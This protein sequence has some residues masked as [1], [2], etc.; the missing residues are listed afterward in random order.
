MARRRYISSEIS[1]DSKLNKVSDFAALLYTWGIAQ[2]R[3]DCRISP[4]N[5]EELRSRVVPGRNK[6]VDDVE[7]ALQELFKAELLGIDQNGEIYYP[8]KSFYKYQTYINAGNRRETPGNA[9]SLSPS[10]SPS[11]KEEP[12]SATPGF[13]NKRSDSEKKSKEDSPMASMG[14]IPELKAAADAVYNSDPKKFR[15]LAKWIGQGRKHGYLETDMAEALRQFWD[16]RVIDEWY[17]YLDTVLEKVV[18]D[19]NRDRALEE[20]ETFKREVTELGNSARNGDSGVT[21]VLS[22][23]RGLS[24]AKKTN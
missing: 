14:L 4:Q 15:N 20:Y 3:D 2:A 10:P 19:R 16:Y 24:D 5:A 9:S 8:S 23:V 21:P 11:L 18:K 7:K 22:V 13:L 12:D 17:P 1:L 6:S